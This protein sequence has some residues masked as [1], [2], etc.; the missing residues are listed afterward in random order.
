MLIESDTILESQKC[1]YGQ[2]LSSLLRSLQT[3]VSCLPLLFLAIAI[4]ITLVD[5]KI[6]M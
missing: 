2:Y 6:S 1:E 5:L 4:T 3:H